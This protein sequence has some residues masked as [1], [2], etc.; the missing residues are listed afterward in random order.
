[1]PIVKQLQGRLP[2]KLVSTTLD[3][4]ALDDRAFDLGFARRHEALRRSIAEVGILQPLVARPRDV[5]PSY[6]IVCGFG[7]ARVAHDLHLPEIALWELDASAT[8]ADCLRLALFDNL[9]LRSFNPVERAI[10]LTGL[11]QH[12]ERERLLADYMPLVGLPPSAIVLDRALALMNLT[13]RLKWALAEGRIEEK[14]AAA[15]AS[16]L[17]DDQEAFA[18]LLERCRPSVSVARELAEALMDVAR[19]DGLPLREICAMPEIAA[20]LIAEVATDAERTAALRATVRQLRYPRL[21]EREAEF[22]AARAALHL[23]PS[24]RLD[25]APNFESDEML[26]EIRFRSEKELGDAAA[27][28]SR[29]LDD[30]TLLRRLMM[31]D[32]RGTMNEK[33]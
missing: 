28:L 23:P 21:S 19:R 9:P 15:L 17:P 7:R 22:G 8:D 25:P 27:L 14:V 4:L 33:R 1:L 32:E 13:E 6:Q 30:P 3:R 29:R 24:M 18:R 12:V 20:S 26:L 11:G 2:L 5:S 16:L 31:N 10:I